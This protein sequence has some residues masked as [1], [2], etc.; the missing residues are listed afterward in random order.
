MMV[1]G[2]LLPVASEWKLDGTR[3]GRSMSMA[4]L[5]G[6]GDLDIVINNL[7][8]PAQIFENQ[9]CAGDSLQV[10]LLWSESGNTDALGA[11][12]VLETGNGR[13][14]REIRATSGYLSGDPA[15]IHFGFPEGTELQ[16][17]EIRW[18]DGSVSILDDLSANT[19]LLIQR[20]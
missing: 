18:P 14:L 6:D 13:Y 2:V 7:M 11:E 19:L 12:L 15:R 5:D 3:S 20:S 4:D 16:Q 9:L 8:M 1:A 17:L 10:D